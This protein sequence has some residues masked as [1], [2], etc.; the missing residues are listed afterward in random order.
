MVA[1]DNVQ[2]QLVAL[3]T[4]LKGNKKNERLVKLGITPTGREMQ[5]G[6]FDP[7]VLRQDRNG[8]SCSFSLVYSN[9]E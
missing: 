9:T 7:K 6:R 5:T 4:N 1:L 2:K 3:V 8:Q